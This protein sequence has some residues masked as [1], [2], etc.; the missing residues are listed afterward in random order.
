MNLHDLIEQVACELYQRSGREEGRD[1]N[2]WIKAE[3]IVMNRYDESGDLNEIFED[4]PSLVS[5]S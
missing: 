3:S 1:L 5:A 4:I 2:N